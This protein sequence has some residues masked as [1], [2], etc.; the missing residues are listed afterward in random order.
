[1]KGRGIVTGRNEVSC[2]GDRFILALVFTRKSCE[3]EEKST[4]GEIRKGMADMLPGYLV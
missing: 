2:Y 4:R 1:M 3:E